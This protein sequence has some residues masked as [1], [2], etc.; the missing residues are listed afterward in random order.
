MTNLKIAQSPPTFMISD[1]VD[2][3]IS[4]Y[5]PLSGTNSVTDPDSVDGSSANIVFKTT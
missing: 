2:D 3:Y 1:N 4:W 5:E